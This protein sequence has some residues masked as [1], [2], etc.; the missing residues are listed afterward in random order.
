MMFLNII[1]PK[2]RLE[3]HSAK[4]R[5][6]RKN[7]KSTTEEDFFFTFLSFDRSRVEKLTHV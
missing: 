1:L 7:V 5:T 6:T 4:H 3:I 2:C